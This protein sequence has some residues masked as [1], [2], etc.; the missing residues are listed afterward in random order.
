MF[1]RLLLGSSLTLLLSVTLLI[2]W[3]SRPSLSTQ[4]WHFGDI[5]STKASTPI[6]TQRL[7]LMTYNIGFAGGNSGLTDT[8]LTLAQSQQNLAAIIETIKAHNPD[9][10]ALQSRRSNYVNQIEEIATKSGYPYVAITYTW[11]CRWVPYPTNLKPWTQ[12]AKTT[13]ANAVFSKHPILGQHII[14]FPKPKKNNWIYNL[15]YLDRVAQ[16]VQ[17]QYNTT[18][19]EIANLHLEAWNKTE[20]ESQMSTMA[21]YL[22]TT[23]HPIIITG[24]FNTT[25]LIATK[26]H[27]FPDDPR[28]DYRDDSTLTTLLNLPHITDTLAATTP[29]EESKHWTF[30]ANTPSRRLDYIL[31]NAKDWTIQNTQISQPAP[32]SDHLPV[33]TELTAKF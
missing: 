12:F 2:W 30:P 17:I 26:K 5:I 28:D 14:R 22:T 4:Q 11:D 7:S 19:I 15:F 33:V 32:S 16:I 27:Q 20:R 31:I 9:I 25:P 13:A 24:D 3:M 18:V 1:W 8:R 21:A 6:C 29:L 23:R 10:L